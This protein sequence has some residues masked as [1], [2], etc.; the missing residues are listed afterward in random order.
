MPAVSR[1][2]GASGA[3]P[4]GFA[5]GVLVSASAACSASATL[6]GSPLAW[7]CRY[8]RRGDS[9]SRWL[10][11]AV[12]LTPICCSFV[13][14][15]VTSL[16]SSTRSPIAIALLL[17]PLN[18]TQ[19]PSASAG[20]IPTLPTR[21][22]RSR[23]GKA[24][25]WTSPGSSVPDRPIARSTALHSVVSGDG[26]WPPPGVWAQTVVAT[27]SASAAGTTAMTSSSSDRGR[28]D[29]QHR[30]GPAGRVLVLLVHRVH[31]H[32]HVVARPGDRE[33]VHPAGGA[34]G[35]EGAVRLVLRVVLGALELGVARVPPERGVLVRAG[36]VE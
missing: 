10:C 5:G 22:W 32:H 35:H 21:T 24:Y 4:A 19:P 13:R 28:S 12:S 2:K 15:G 20:L 27:A 14:T 1:G 6:T 16:W 33:P 18:A 31:I 34:P 26:V 3:P 29:L 11:N 36:K 7:M 9:S 8:I 30:R 25:L 23:R 17:V